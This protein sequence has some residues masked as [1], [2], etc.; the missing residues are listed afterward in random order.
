MKKASI[1]IFLRLERKKSVVY[2][3]YTAYRITKWF[4]LNIF[5]EPEHWDENKK[6]ILKK[7][8]YYFSKNQELE[9]YVHRANE[10]LHKANLNLKILT[11]N[12]FENAFKNN[13]SNVQL[14]NEFALKEKEY[15]KNELSKSTIK[16]N[17]V[18]Q[19]SKINRYN[20]KLTL[21]EINLQFIRNYHSY[22]LN[23][24]NNKE[25][26]AFS[27]HRWLKAMINRAI[28]LN[29]LDVNPYKDFPIKHCEGHREFLT[30][31]ELNKIQSIY[32]EKTLKANKQNVLKYF[33]FSCYTGLRYT[34]MYN[35]C[36]KNIVELDNGIKAVAITLHKTKVYV[37]IPLNEKALNLISTGL[38]NEKVFKVLTNQPTNRYTK[39]IMKI[40][41]IDRNITFHS[42]RH[43]FASI[44]LSLGIPITTIQ[45]I[46]GHKD[47]K[48]TQIYAKVQNDLKIDALKLFDK[49]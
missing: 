14:F 9:N 38:E 13:F 10:I 41:G 15:L 26:T 43:T 21:C 3:S 47:L 37:E 12:E 23:E 22:M 48:H 16:D 40:A 42:A 34:D 39:E 17:Y 29:L 44:G 49:I 46:L 24:L 8:I 45:N 6:T 31:D 4:S 32:N 19:I 35:L 28:K 30:I 2:L 5:V 36:F 25:S 18:K 7:D 27:S 1:R 20:S 33:L 11:V